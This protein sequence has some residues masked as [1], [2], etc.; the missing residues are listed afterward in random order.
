MSF[1]ECPCQAGGKG[2]VPWP[3]KLQLG[4]SGR[5]CWWP[6]LFCNSG[7]RPLCSIPGPAWGA[8]GCC[9][10]LYH[11]VNWHRKAHSCLWLLEH[12]LK[13]ADVDLLFPALPR[14]TFYSTIYISKRIFV[15]KRNGSFAGMDVHLVKRKTRSFVLLGVTYWTETLKYFIYCQFSTQKKVALSES[16]LV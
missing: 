2:A 1:L 3:G 8:L 13:N 9:L 16:D 15:Y 14:T 11:P 6:S 7:T 10:W 4:C 12:Q 5:G